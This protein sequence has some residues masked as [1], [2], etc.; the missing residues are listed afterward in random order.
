MSTTTLLLTSKTR[1]ELAA[2]YCL[3]A[4]DNTTVEFRQ[5]KRSIP[6]N[7]RFHAMCADV[8]RQIGWTD[9]F[10]RPIK[11][12]EENWKRFF[13]AAWKRETLIV[14]NESGSGFYDLGVRSSKL[15]KTDFMDLIEFVSAFGAERGVV[16]HDPAEKQ[17]EETERV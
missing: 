6:Q 17:P 14:P 11:M 5:N 10:G 4:P 9:V 3:S 13:L 2:S 16:F 7:A 12:T 8:A 15:T 1:R